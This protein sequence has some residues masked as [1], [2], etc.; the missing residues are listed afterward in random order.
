M[1]GNGTAGYSGNNGLAVSAEMNEATGV[2]VDSQGDLFIADTDNNV[3]REVN[4]TTHFITTVVGNGTAGYSG[5]NG[6]AVSAELHGPY[7]VALDSQG[8]IFFSDDLNS[9]IREVNAT[10][11]IITTVAGNGTQGYSGNNGPAVSA[12]LSYPSGVALDSQGDL[13]IAERDS[14]VIREVNATTHVITTVAGNGT[15]GDSGDNGPAASAELNQPY[16]VAVDSQGDLFISDSGNNVIREVNATTHVITTV[17]GNHTQGYS[18]D[19]GLAASA[20]LFAPAGVA[21]DSQGDLFIADTPNKVI[22]EVNA[23]THVITTVA[24]NGTQGDSGDNGPAVQRRTEESLWHGVGQPRRPLH[25]RHRQQRHPRG[26]G[27]GAGD[28]QRLTGRLRAR[29]RAD[30]GHHLD[31][32]QLHGQGGRSAVHQRRDQL[33]RHRDEP[34]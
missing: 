19:N 9:V 24:G 6:P 30:H 34:E 17:A 11:H 28:Q 32:Q 13:F 26:G 33:Q 20:E 22:R 7:G 3:I 16:G 27:G 10:T 14:G 18:G 5:N 21:V 31:E 23:T 1:A 8:D 29:R 2:A 15:Q 12:E 25:R 4:A